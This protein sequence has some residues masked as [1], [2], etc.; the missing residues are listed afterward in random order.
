MDHTKTIHFLVGSGGGGGFIFEI[1]L[2]A[3]QSTLHDEI[4]EKCIHLSSRF[5]I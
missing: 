3:L 4:G 1:S 5:L 2:I